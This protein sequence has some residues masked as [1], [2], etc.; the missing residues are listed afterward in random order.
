MLRHHF[1]YALSFLDRAAE[2]D[3]DLDIRQTHVLAR[4]QQ[5]SAF[6]R[7][8]LGIA[9][10]IRDLRGDTYGDAACFDG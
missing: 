7:E 10:I 5:G 4:A 3:H 8:T 1:D 2:R 9:R 6:Q